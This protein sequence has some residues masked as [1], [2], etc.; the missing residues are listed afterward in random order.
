MGSSAETRILVCGA[1]PEALDRMRREL[2]GPGRHIAGFVAGHPEPVEPAAVDLVVFEGDGAAAATFLRRLRARL[3]GHFVPVLFVT[4][5]PASDGCLSALDAGAAACLRRPFGSGELRAQVDALLRIKDGHDR[6]RASTAEAQNLNRQ[7]QSFHQRVS[8]ELELARRIQM[9]L[10]PQQL[11]QLPG[12][13]FAVHY[14]PC[15]RV[16][17]DFYDIFRLDECHVGFYVA[18]A[19][20]HGVPASLLTM[21]LKKAVRGKEINGTTYRLVPP[22]EVLHRLNRD[23]LEQGLAENPFVTMV[24]GLF[25]F[26]TGALQIARAGHPHPVHLPAAGAPALLE[27]HGSLLGVFETKFPMLTRTLESGDRI[28]FHTDGT[29]TIAFEGRPPG[30]ESLLACAA[31]HRDLPLPQQVER[32]AADLCRQAE[33]PDDFTLLGLEFGRTGEE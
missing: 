4:D 11:P 31:R 16:G 24:Y 18:D 26:Q 29:D 6:L 33:A 30:A 7:L 8:Q 10:L 2:E 20:G 13:R 19:M 21:F 3:E 12:A 28:L 17:G 5:G 32:I 15:G 27:V 14:R 1:R 22:G 23:L 25:N 9:S